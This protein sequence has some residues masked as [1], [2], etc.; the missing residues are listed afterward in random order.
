MKQ[1]YWIPTE[2]FNKNGELG[3]SMIFDRHPFETEY[4]TL[5]ET[6]PH[7]KEVIEVSEFN[8]LISYK[9]HLEKHVENGFKIIEDLMLAISKLVDR[10]ELYQN[11][12]QKYTV[13]KQFWPEDMKQNPEQIAIEAFK[14]AAEYERSNKNST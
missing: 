12:L 13:N 6:N 7:Y 2:G 11:A 14:E 9:D 10:N 4:P 3:S 8:K 5:L 1:T